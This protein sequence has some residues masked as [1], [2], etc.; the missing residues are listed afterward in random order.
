MDSVILA[1]VLAATSLTQ[2]APQIL[3]ISKAASAADELF[4]TIDRPSEIDVFSNEGKKPEDCKG[5][6][7]I[8]DVHFAYPAR[9]TTKVLNGMSLKIPANKTTALVGASG[10]GKSTI[11]GLLERWYNPAEGKMFLDG[12]EISDLNLRWLRTKI[13]VVQQEPVLF[14]GSI[15]E[16]VAHGMEGTELMSL[17]KEEKMRLVIEACK[18]AYAHEFIMSTPEVRSKRIFNRESSNTDR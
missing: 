11:V 15:F 2:I 8:Q 10:S 16:N 4:K 9:P 6:L 3:H 12:V 7:E 18:D 13:R 1:V 17:P 14:R 5:V